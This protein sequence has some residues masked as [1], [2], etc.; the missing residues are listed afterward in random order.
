M[1]TWQDIRLIRASPRDQVSRFLKINLA[2]IRE[3]TSPINSINDS[4]NLV[5]L[6]PTAFALYFWIA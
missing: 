1:S 5:T 4:P 3:K 2:I 6:H